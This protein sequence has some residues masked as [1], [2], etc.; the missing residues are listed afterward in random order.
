MSDHNFMVPPVCAVTSGYVGGR[1]GDTRNGQWVGPRVLGHARLIA[2]PEARAAATL[3][4]GERGPV[5]IKLVAAAGGL[6]AFSCEFRVG[7]GLWLEL[8]G[9]GAELLAFYIG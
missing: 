9:E 8:A 6:D 1:A 2:G 4:D 3:R 5:L 7:A